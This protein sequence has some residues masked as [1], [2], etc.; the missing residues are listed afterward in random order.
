[1]SKPKSKPAMPEGLA[2][3]HSHI[4]TDI[5]SSVWEHRAV[6]CPANEFD[7]IA[8]KMDGWELVAVLPSDRRVVTGRGAGYIEG[9]VTFWKRPKGETKD[10]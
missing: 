7:E 2:L 8:L 1:M 6:Y 9:F 4:F 5:R 3:P 10:V